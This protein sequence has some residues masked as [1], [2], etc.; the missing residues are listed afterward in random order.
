MET[1][2]DF[3]RLIVVSFVFIAYLIMLFSIITDLIRD[4]ETSGWVKAIWALF[5]IFLPFLTALAYLIFRG[6]GMNRRSHEVA[7]QLQQA[8]DA[9]I[10]GVAGTSPAQ[11][12][13]DA[14]VLLDAGTITDEEFQRLKTRA[15][16]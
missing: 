8:Q 1:F 2:W 11:Q 10:K 4:R 6:D 3:F 7:T 9:Y 13:A 16:A 5:L 15:L 14:K 12:I